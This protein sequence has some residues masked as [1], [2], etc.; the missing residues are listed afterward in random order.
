MAQRNDKGVSDA[1]TSQVGENLEQLRNSA[2]ETVATASGIAEFAYDE[3]RQQFE[4]LK[5]DIAELS[6]SVVRAGQDSAK[7]AAAAA[8]DA[9]RK[10][11]DEAGERVSYATDHVESALAEAEDFARRR[12]GVALGLAAGA[13]FLLALSMS[14]R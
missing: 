7:G 2:G 9:G 8:R 5:S 3:L 1:E 4:T 13:G 12:P 10:A 14:R 11:M 6:A